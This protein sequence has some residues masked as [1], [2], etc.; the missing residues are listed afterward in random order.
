MYFLIPL[1]KYS[2]LFN[3]TKGERFF[4]TNCKDCNLKI[5][6]YPAFLL[7][8]NYKMKKVGEKCVF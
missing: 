8:R 4:T 3:T 6:F 1:Q 5:T 7:F 2:F